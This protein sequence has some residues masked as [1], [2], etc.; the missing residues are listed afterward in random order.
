MEQKSQKKTTSSDT[1][2][3]KTSTDHNRGFL[4][5]LRKNLAWIVLGLEF[6]FF[7]IMHP[8]FFSVHNLGNVLKQGAPLFI[9]ATGGTFVILMGE[10]D[11]SADGLINLC[12]IVSVLIASKLGGS[13]YA[14]WVPI[15]IAMVI[16]STVT[17]LIGLVFTRFKLPAVIVSFGFSTICYG[18]GLIISNGTTIRA[19]S[20]PF[21][22]VGTGSVLGIPILGIVAIIVLAIGMFLGW[23]TRFGRYTYAIGGG[24]RVAE[25]CGVPINRYKTFVFTL[26]GAL[27]GTSG[28][29]MSSR[30]GAA[31]NTQ[32]NGMALDAVAAVVMGGTALSGG[33]GGVSRTIAGVLVLILLSNGLNLMGVPHYTQVLVKG[34]V[35]IL[36]VA[37]FK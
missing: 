23:R 17:T 19:I 5:I 12:G 13:A 24:A 31:S 28:A 14:R 33:K 10:V 34:I 22:S 20:D 21:K 1:C 16:G 29:L 30:L 8:N 25:L 9:V 15:F 35:V 7:A 6:L 37:F 3:E 32:G 18:L 26:A 36:A 4:E 27:T 2:S 11:F